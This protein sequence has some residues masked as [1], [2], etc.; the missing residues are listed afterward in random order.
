MTKNPAVITDL[1]LSPLQRKDS[2]SAAYASGINT[3][4]MP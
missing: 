1:F 2:A 3:A 4:L